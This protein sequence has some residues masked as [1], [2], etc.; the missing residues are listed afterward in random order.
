MRQQT[1]MQQQMH[2][3]DCAR[4]QQG[5]LHV[6]KSFRLIGWHGFM[7]PDGAYMG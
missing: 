1:G 2:A 5:T 4:M 7:L 3:A 6:E